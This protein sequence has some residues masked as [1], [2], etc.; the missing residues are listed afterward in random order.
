MW[1]L[2]ERGASA[3]ALDYYNDN[4]LSWA[5]LKN[6]LERTSILLSYGTEVRVINLKGQTPFSCLVALLVRGLGTEKED[7]VLWAPPQSCWTLWIKEKWYHATKSGQ[8]PATEWKTDCSVFSPR[9]FKNTLLSVVC[10]SLTLQYL[11]DEGPSTASFSD[12][13][14]ATCTGAWRCSHHQAGTPGEVSPCSTVS[15]FGKQEKPSF[16]L[17]GLYLEVT[18]HNSSLHTTFPSQTKPPN[19]KKNPSFLF[20][21]YGLFD[22]I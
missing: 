16:L 21:V 18:C 8:R 1:A 12:R 14:P 10:C 9:N 15:F 5:A 19:K 22:F 17:Y 11:P 20:S 3:S 13:I 4:P 6:N 2:L 7:L